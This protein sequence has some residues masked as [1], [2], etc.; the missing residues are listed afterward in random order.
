MITRSTTPM[1]PVEAIEEALACLNADGIQSG[2]MYEGLVNVLKI[3]STCRDALS[4]AKLVARQLAARNYPIG[5]S[6]PAEARLDAAL[7]SL[8]GVK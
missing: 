4:M 7:L 8:K 1:P 5:H 3:L 6:G 2:D